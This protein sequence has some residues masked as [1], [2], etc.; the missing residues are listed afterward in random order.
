M[1]SMVLASIGVYAALFAT[2]SW[3]YDEMQRFGILSVIVV[4]CIFL[5]LRVNKIRK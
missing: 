4:V 3:L 5:L 2:G 1:L